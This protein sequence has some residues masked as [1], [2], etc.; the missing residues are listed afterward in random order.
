MSPS[1][2][3][4]LKATA[5]AGALTALYVTVGALPHTARAQSS[6]AASAAFAD[7]HH[8]G[9]KD[10]AALYQAICQGCHMP[11]AKGATG[12]G[13]YPALAGNPNLEAAGYPVMMVLHGQKAMPPIGEFLSDDQVAAVVNYVRT[14]FGNHYTDAVTVEDVK[15]AR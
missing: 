6:D 3:F 7:P 8:F 4:A 15:A 5:F 1:K 14:H 12:A 2:S 9:Q 13:T 10:G 11:D